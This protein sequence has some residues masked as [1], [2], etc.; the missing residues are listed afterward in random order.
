[1]TGYQPM[2]LATLARHLTTAEDPSLRWDL[3]WEFLQEY[4][5]E[6]P[7]S[8]FALLREEPPPTGDE[9]WDV[10]LAAL[11]EYVA[12]GEDIATPDWATRRALERTWFPFDRPASKAEAL[13]TAPMAF[14]RRGIFLSASNLDA[15]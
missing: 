14:R 1:M 9:R 5:W 13:V 15:A 2:T 8:R 4:R 12:A 3:V 11:A 10:L 7:G 6:E